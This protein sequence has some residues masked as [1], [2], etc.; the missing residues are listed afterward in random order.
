MC[1]PYINTGRA[2]LGMVLASRRELLE[3]RLRAID[4]QAQR[5]DLRARLDNLSLD[6]AP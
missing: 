5:A 6:T 1:M 2:D 4:L 3:L